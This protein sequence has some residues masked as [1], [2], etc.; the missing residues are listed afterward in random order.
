VES[1]EALLADH[2][3]E[4]VRPISEVCGAIHEWLKACAENHPEE[5]ALNHQEWRTGR[6]YR[7]HGMFVFMHAGKS[8]MLGRLLYGRETLRT[9]KCPEHDG[10]WS[11]IEFSD[12]VCQYGC[13]L[14]GWLP[15]KEDNK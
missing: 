6:V 7:D 1:A 9:E 12:N 2:Y 15:A 3:G 13:Q 8:N 5:D 10:H 11:G 4:P 14:T